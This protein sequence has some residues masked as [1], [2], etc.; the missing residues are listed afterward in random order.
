MIKENSIGEKIVLS[1]KSEFTSEFV[2][3]YFE[4]EINEK[5]KQLNEYLNAYNA[6]RE[7]DT[8]NR[9]YIETLIFLLKSEIKGIQKICQEGSFNFFNTIDYF[10]KLKKKNK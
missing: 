4:A 5:E 2:Q 10:N 9:Q 7:K 8:F 1:S 3:G 6:I